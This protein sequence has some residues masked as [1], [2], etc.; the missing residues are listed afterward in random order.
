MS[1]KNKLF[2]VLWVIGM[3]GILSLLLLDIPLPED[4][5]LPPLWIIKLL[6][7]FQQTVLLSIAVIIKVALAEKVKLSAPLAEAIAKKNPLMPVIKPQILPGMIGDFIGD[8]A[9]VFIALLWQPF[10]PSDFVTKSS[11]ISN[12]LPFITRILFGGITEEL[13]IRWGLM[14]LLVWIGWKIFQRGKGKPQG[15][16][17]VMAI[18]LSS[19]LFGV[20]HLP[21]AF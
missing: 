21:I 14:I 2:W 3:I 17:F 8:L 12:N 18:L 20:G 11:E 1:Y 7:L 13:L 19:L 16:Y 9:L 5:K 10:L 4:N 6:T 15:R